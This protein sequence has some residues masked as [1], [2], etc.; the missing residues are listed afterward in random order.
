[1]IKIKFNTSDLSLTQSEC[2]YNSQPLLTVEIDSH[3]MRS[4][5][6]QIID[7]DIDLV[8]NEID[9]YYNT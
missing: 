4:I 8:N 2:C 9:D 7:Y 1:M 5:I 3:A 6:H